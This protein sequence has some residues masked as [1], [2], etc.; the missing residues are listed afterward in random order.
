MAEKAIGDAGLS[1]DDIDFENLDDDIAH[2]KSSA[3]NT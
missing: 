3:D 1:Y 2:S